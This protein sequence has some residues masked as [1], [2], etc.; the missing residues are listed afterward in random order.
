VQLDRSSRWYNSN[1]TI[2]MEARMEITTEAMTEAAK[3]KPA[4]E[5]AAPFA[6]LIPSLKQAAVDRRRLGS[7]LI[8]EAEGFEQ[9]VAGYEQAIGVA[10]GRATETDT[11]QPITA[12]GGAPDGDTGPRGMEAVRRVMREVGG[13]LNAR[14]VHAHLENRGWVSPEAK[15][16]LRGTEAAINRLYRMGELER[17]SRGRYRYKWPASQQLAVDNGSGGDDR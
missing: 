1:S 7:A 11:A 8:R 5:V 3:L 10:I 9:M 15:F 13:D 16:P 6:T 4:E 17:V 14:E 12:H 2:E